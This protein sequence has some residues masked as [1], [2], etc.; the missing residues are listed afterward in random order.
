L[1]L[2]EFHYFIRESISTYSETNFLKPNGLRGVRPSDLP[3]A[4]CIDNID[5]FTG[6]KCGITH[7]LLDVGWNLAGVGQ[8]V[9]Y[10][11]I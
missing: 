8:A 2:R 11:Y 1:A 3:F 10:F 9:S 5:L 4:D 7:G 6:N